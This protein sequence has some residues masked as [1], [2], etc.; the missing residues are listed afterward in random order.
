M[1]FQ[2]TFFEFKNDQGYLFGHMCKIPWISVIG[3]DIADSQFII[4]FLSKKFNVNFASGYSSVEN[5]IARAFFQLVDESLVWYEL[6]Q[7][8][9]F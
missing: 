5:G 4:E 7:L 9:G 1:T 6:E 2:G 3:Q 8:L